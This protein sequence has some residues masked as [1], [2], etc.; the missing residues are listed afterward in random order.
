MSISF[1]IRVAGFDF[2]PDKFKASRSI[3][4]TVGEA[5][6]RLL[7]ALDRL[8]GLGLVEK[9]TFYVIVSVCHQRQWIT[10]DR[11]AEIVNIK[12]DVIAMR[13][14]DLR[15][16]N[17]PNDVRLIALGC[18]IAL[19]DSMEHYVGSGRA[20]CRVCGEKIAKGAK[21]WAFLH[22]FQDDMQR[23]WTAVECKAHAACL[24]SASE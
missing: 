7:V 21:G 12:R 9:W 6:E 3:N 8:F 1:P 10:L 4:E 24:P 5:T 18:E 17:R 20:T 15:G 22:N 14:G 16:M 23:G 11:L 2:D 13:M 19:P